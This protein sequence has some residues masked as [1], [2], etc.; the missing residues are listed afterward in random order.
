MT[1]LIIKRNSEWNSRARKFGIY[2]ND[3]KIG[4][5]ANG[6]TK[7]FQI[8]SGK[9]KINGKIDW[10]KSPIIDFEIAENESKT[11]EISGYK[12]G[13]ILLQMVTVFLLIAFLS[14]YSLPIISKIFI[15]FVAIGFLFHL[16]YLTFGKNRYLRIIDQK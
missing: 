7:E 11:I 3:K 8:D 14:K 12:Y 13:N 15:S 1:K 6:E 10:C 16:Y 5:I 9:H 4:T 2:L